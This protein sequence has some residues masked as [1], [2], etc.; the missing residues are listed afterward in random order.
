MPRADAR[1]C[2]LRAVGVCDA[3]RKIASIM[4]VH[5]GYPVPAKL[6]A[7]VRENGR[8]RCGTH[9]AK[10]K[11]IQLRTALDGPASHQSRG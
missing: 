8:C 7:A 5:T 3:T 9:L 11:P 2:V 6:R 1:A 10:T 4:R